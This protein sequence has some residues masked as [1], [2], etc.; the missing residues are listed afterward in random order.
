M[1]E[2]YSKIDK[3]ELAEMPKVEFTGAIKIIDTVEKADA[4]I[5]ELSQY[6]VVGFD[7]ETKPSFKR[8]ITNKVSLLQLATDEAAYLFRLHLIGITDSIVDF[9]QN[10][11]ILKIGISVRDDFQALRKKREIEPKGFVEIQEIA[12]R[13]GIEDRSLQKIYALLFRERISKSQR[14]S[15]W[16]LETLTESQMQYAAIDAWATIKIYRYLKQIIDE[17]NFKVIHRDAEESIAKEG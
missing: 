13:M 7:T 15:N 8:G 5:A 9:L 2:I 12:A 11:K 1:V 14:L 3:T 10:E 16:E 4:A 6:S 17:K